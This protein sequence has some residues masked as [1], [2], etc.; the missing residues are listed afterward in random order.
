MKLPDLDTTR[1]AMVI[2]G[3]IA[4]AYVVGM[5]YLVYM[6]LSLSESNQALVL[7]TGLGSV[8]TLL[9]ALATF[10]NI[11]QS[12]KR[13]QIQQQ[14]QERPLAVDELSQLIQPAIAAIENNLRQFEES[15]TAGCAFDW[16]HID[17]TT[18][19]VSASGPDPVRVDSYIPA[20]RLL[21]EDPDL[22]HML[23]EHDTIVEEI[24]DHAKRLHTELEPE[25]DRLLEK[26][27]Y[28]EQRTQFVTDSVLKELD[29]WGE[30]AEHYEFWEQYRDHLTRYA[31]EETAVTIEEIQ[32]ME[33]DYKNHLEETLE[34]LIERKARLKRDYS[35]SDDDITN[36][37]EETDPT[38]S[39]I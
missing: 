11:S 5:L 33:R 3:G 31:E 28:S 29:Q 8:G 19:Y 12:N 24:A 14:K 2:S 6:S 32:S 35:I 25:I 27:G 38:R 37:V 10:V 22:H 39:G 15:D 23:D 4:G 30:D 13:L 7:A 1:W 26:E 18:L 9:L 21:S 36:A 16:V 17:S 20:A 34:S